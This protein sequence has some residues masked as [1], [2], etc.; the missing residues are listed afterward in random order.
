MEKGKYSGIDWVLKINEGEV[1][2]ET[3]LAPVLGIKAWQAAQRVRAADW[4]G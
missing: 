1:W 2:L 4:K 3:K